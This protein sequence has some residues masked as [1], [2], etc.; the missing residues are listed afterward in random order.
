MFKGKS[1]GKEITVSGRGKEKCSDK[2]QER[3]NVP[4]EMRGG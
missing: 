1:K 3:K 4:T 2:H